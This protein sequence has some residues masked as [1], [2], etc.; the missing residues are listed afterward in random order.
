MVMSAWG[1]NPPRK[2]IEF[3]LDVKPSAQ[4]T[5]IHQQARECVRSKVS[6][7]LAW[8]TGTEAGVEIGDVMYTDQVSKG[9]EA[10]Q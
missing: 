7:D 3:P 4:L 2:Y 1:Q 8:Y 5:P 10:V 6:G 9:T